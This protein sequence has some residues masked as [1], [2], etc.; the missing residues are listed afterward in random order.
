MT[1]SHFSVD[2][3][4]SISETTHTTRETNKQKKVRKQSPAAAT[5]RSFAPRRNAR[6]VGRAAAFRGRGRE[7]QRER[8]ARPQPH[9]P[10]RGAQERSTMKVEVTVL[11]E[12][13]LPLNNKKKHRGDAQSRTPPLTHTTGGRRRLR[14]SAPSSFLLMLSLKTQNP[15][16]VVTIPKWLRGLTRNQLRSRAQVRILLVT[17]F[18]SCLTR[19]TPSEQKCASQQGRM[20]EWSKAGDSSSLLFVGAGSNPAPVTFCFPHVSFMPKGG[21]HGTYGSIRRMNG[22]GSGGRG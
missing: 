16:R 3:P 19:Q 4:S 18:S 21:C 11:L 20:A 8:P 14:C 10:R 15:A 6:S 17:T 22:K 2:S 5:V 9:Q 7:R 12:R 13:T 1:L